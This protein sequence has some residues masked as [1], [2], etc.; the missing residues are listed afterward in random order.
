MFD[1]HEVESTNIRNIGWSPLG[2]VLQI[3]FRSK[4][5]GQAES[6]Y[7]YDEFPREKFVEF[8][9]SPSKGKWFQANV[10]GR[11]HTRKIQ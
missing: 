1:V 8:L 7:Q 2:S 9:A 11:Y 4:K 5:E 6:I 3:Q 10:R